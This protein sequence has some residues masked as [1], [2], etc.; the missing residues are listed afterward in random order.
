MHTKIFRAGEEISA[1]DVVTH[2]KSAANGVDQWAD[3]LITLAGRAGE[4][5][6]KEFFSYLVDLGPQSANL[7][8][9]CTEMSKKDYKMQWQHILRVVAKR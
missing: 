4:G 6:T 5:M 8:K 1:G 2:L 9:A 3:N 7:V